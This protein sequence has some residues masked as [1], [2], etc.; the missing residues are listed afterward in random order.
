MSRM[1]MKLAWFGRHYCKVLRNSLFA[2]L[3]N[4]WQMTVQ[5]I[6]AKHWRKR[7]L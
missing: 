2:T 6:I 4:L 5:Q 1:E 7:E 3:S